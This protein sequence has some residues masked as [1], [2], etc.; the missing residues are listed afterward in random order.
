[1][2]DTLYFKDDDSRLSFLQGNYV[3][4]TNMKQKDLERI[5]RY[6]MEPINI[7]VHTTNPQLRCQMLHN[8]FA[9]EALQKLDYLYE[10][11]IEMNGQIVL[12]KGYNDGEELDRS[13]R[14]LEKYCPVM[15]SVSVV[16]V[17]LTKFREGLCPLE[18]FTK[19]DA[20]AV[21]DQIEQWQTTFYKKYGLHFI[22]ASDE[23]YILAEKPLPENTR[24]DGYLQLENGV[25]MIRLL[26]DE[27]Q[28]AVSE[29]ESDT[30]HRELSIATGKLAEPY[31][32]QCREMILKKYPNLQIHIY[33]IQNDYFG[34]SITVAGLVTGTDLIKQLKGKKL[35]QCLLLPTQML[36]SGDDVFLD[37]V[38]LSDVQKALQI[39]V[40]RVESSG[41]AFV[42]AIVNKELHLNHYLYEGYEI[43]KIE[44]EGYEYE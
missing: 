16:P 29:L 43:E 3:T 15:K 32:V 28:E 13:I 10:H 12:C 37:D 25:G 11:Q 34:Q 40:I 42:E 5:V 9:G 18:P 1:M 20:I 31:L 27:V 2:R 39:P 7:S 38:K 24:Y 36:R 8:R 22:H 14:D 17:G 44:K 30:S 33:P 19:E 4:L 41:Q 26:L 35:G 6:H 21:I 23:F